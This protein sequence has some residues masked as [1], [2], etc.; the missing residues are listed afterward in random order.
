[1][2]KNQNQ[3]NGLQI[4]DKYIDQAFVVLMCIIFAS[5]IAVCFL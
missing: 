1:M 3:Q 2:A 5:I 4:K